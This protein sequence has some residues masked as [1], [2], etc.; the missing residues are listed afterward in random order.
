MENKRAKGPQSLALVERVSVSCTGLA[1]SGP[2]VSNELGEP[3]NIAL[4]GS[5][6]GL[7]VRISKPEGGPLNTAT[8][9]LPT[10]APALTSALENACL[11]A[12]LANDNK[13]RDVLV[14]DMRGIT[15]LY[16]Y[17]VLATAVTRRQI[18]KIADD[19]DAALR[20]RGEQ[21]LSIEGYEASTWV[22]QDYGDVVVHLFTPET[23][24]YYHLEELW[25]DSP[26]IDWERY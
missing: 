14:L 6:V 25:E 22:V 8:V 2:E 11:C 9:S 15:P 1:R 21:R 17:L 7:L 12:R 5:P 20:S 23:R 26:R 3:V 24:Q 18:H 10:A 19:V 16:D 4:R 13:A